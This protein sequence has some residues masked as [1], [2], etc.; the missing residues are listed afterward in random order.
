MSTSDCRRMRAAAVWRCRRA[1]KIPIRGAAMR[2]E[3][4]HPADPW[5]DVLKH[6]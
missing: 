5:P 6:I 4:F 1:A 3:I 2:E